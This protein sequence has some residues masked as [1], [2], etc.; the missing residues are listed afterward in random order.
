MKPKTKLM[1]ASAYRNVETAASI[2]NFLRRPDV[3]GVWRELHSEELRIRYS[4][5]NIIRKSKSRRTRYTGP[6]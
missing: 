1:R 5:E 4:S 6:L 3:T 2:A